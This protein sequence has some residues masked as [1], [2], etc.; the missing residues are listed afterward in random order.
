MD[1]TITVKATKDCTLEA[2]DFY[3]IPLR[4]GMQRELNIQFLA[5]AM[6]SGC[7]IVK[8]PVIAAVAADVIADMNAAA[9]RDV[10]VKEAVIAVI[11]DGIASEFTA[12]N[13]PKVSVVAERAGVPVTAAEINA[14]ADSYLNG[15]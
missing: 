2:P 6:N 1:Q 12:S 9:D 4:E 3:P 8:D 10:R 11:V 14:I 5:S 7:E 15:E 13:K